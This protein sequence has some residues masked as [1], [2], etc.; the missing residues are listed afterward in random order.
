MPRR[1]TE[2]PLADN[3]DGCASSSQEEDLIAGAYAGKKP[4][5]TAISVRQ[6]E[7]S[8]HAPDADR[9]AT[10][11]QQDSNSVDVGSIVVEAVGA[12]IAAVGAAAAVKAYRLAQK[13]LALNTTQ[14]EVELRDW[15]NECQR[16][17]DQI[18]RQRDA[19][20]LE[21]ERTDVGG[22]IGGARLP[23]AAHQF[24]ATEQDSGW[25]EVRLQHRPV[26]GTVEQDIAEESV[27]RVA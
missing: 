3:A 21:P 24:I 8:G 25:V 19:L 9:L 5:R 18:E 15:Q 16:L 2:Q 17:Q 10:L 23:R 14:R 11:R 27:S 22:D 26:E 20:A 4:V 12:F 6:D 1:S 13:Q 7:H